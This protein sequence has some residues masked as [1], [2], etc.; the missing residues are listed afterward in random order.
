MSTRFFLIYAN[1][2]WSA[3]YADPQ[4][5][6]QKQVAKECAGVPSERV[7]A[8]REF[9]RQQSKDASHGHRVTE[10]RA[11][12][13]PAKGEGVIPDGCIV[14]VVREVLATEKRAKEELQAEAERKREALARSDWDQLTEAER[15]WVMSCWT[16]RYRPIIDRSAYSGTAWC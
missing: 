7:E 2:C 16:M 12:A 6:E 4:T 11:W 1:V 8:L 13:K 15:A 5:S 9:V 3:A 14:G 10:A